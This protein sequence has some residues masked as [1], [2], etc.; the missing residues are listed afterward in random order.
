MSEDN[1]KKIPM[2]KIDY[3]VDTISVNSHPHF[4]YIRKKKT[5]TNS[6]TKPQ[7]TQAKPVQTSSAPSKNVSRQQRPAPS[8]QK[9]TEKQN[10]VQT[11]TTEVNQSN[12]QEAKLNTFAYFSAKTNTLTVNY[13]A[14]TNEEYKNE[15]VLVHENKHYTNMKNGLYQYPVSPSN[16][17]KLNMYD[18]ISAHIASLLDL[19]QKY[20]ETGDISVL[21]AEQGR[22]YYYKNA[23]ASGEIKPGSNNPEDFD[24]EMKLIANGTQQMWEKHFANTN[25]YT[26]QCSAVASN[27]YDTEGKYYKY[28]EENYQRGKKIAMTVGGV[29]FS[30]YLEKDVE[31]P[32]KGY[33]MILHEVSSYNNNR[34]SCKFYDGSYEGK[35]NG[36]ENEPINPINTEEKYRKWEDK[37]GN[38]VSPV[39]QM[40]IPDMEADFIQKPTGVNSDQ[41]DNSADL[42]NTL[43]T[44]AQET[45]GNVEKTN[46]D[47]E[48]L[49]AQMKEAAEAH[50]KPQEQAYQYSH[51]KPLNE[52]L[53]ESAVNSSVTSLV[54]EETNDNTAELNKTREKVAAKQNTADENSN[55][56]TVAENSS[57]SRTDNTQQVQIQMMKQQREND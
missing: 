3:Q 8:P 42:R 56:S 15:D 9:S 1:K 22:F 37:D 50:K 36:P 23:V 32:K 33:N 5:S 19:R 43:K 27:Y 10:N 38:R 6:Q 47:T 30:Q 34:R 4:F 21:S 46:D 49:K 54:N 28:N 48:Q 39:L 18:E 53:Q 31:I 2:K 29:D 55:V 44:Q 41:Q 14:D 26:Q 12:P 35:Y 24:K 16:A 17:Y 7:N 25:G 57:P 40:E 13:A 52:Q 11:K 45:R 20:I 51:D